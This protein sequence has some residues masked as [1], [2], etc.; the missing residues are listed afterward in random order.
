MEGMH[1]RMY[2]EC[3]LSSSCGL[4]RAQP[5]GQGLHLRGALVSIIVILDLHVAFLLVLLA[6]VVL[7]LLLLDL[8]RGDALRSRPKSKRGTVTTEDVN[9]RGI[10][11]ISSDRRGLGRKSRT[12]Q[13][14]RLDPAL[15]PHIDTQ[16]FKER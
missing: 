12:V 5:F 4:D 6:L 8:H 11:T 13:Y 7:V 16:R 15:E 14:Y 2:W 1:K 9:R 3:G 10:P